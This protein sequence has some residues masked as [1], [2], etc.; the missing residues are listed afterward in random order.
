MKVNGRV[1]K[2][3]VEECK[4]GKMVQFIKVIGKII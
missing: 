3:V 4:F 2:E 1:I